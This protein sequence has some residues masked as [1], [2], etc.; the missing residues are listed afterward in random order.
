M[1][2]YLLWTS[3]VPAWLKIHY[4]PSG[5][6]GDKWPPTAKMWNI[7]V[8]QELWIL[9]RKIHI[10]LEVPVIK[11]NLE[12]ECVYF[13]SEHFLEVK[14]AQTKG[15]KWHCRVMDRLTMPFRQH[16]WRLLLD[17]HLRSGDRTKTLWR[18]KGRV[19]DPVPAAR[20]HVTSMEQLIWSAECLE[21]L[22]SATASQ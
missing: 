21:P 18:S 17:V 1:C 8:W 12:D 11:P 19:L 22:V 3:S 13:H 6:P 7:R 5:Q 4:V 14:A 15:R 16:R 9:R 2:S 10:P 20:G